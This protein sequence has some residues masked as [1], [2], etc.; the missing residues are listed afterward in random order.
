MSAYGGVEGTTPRLD[1]LAR[2]GLRYER[3]YSAGAWTL[4][5]HMTLFTGLLPEQ[6]G[7]HWERVVAPDALA[8]PAA[9]D[10]GT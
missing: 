8:A 5:A 10:P 7:V 9:I 6:H 4:P 2:E 1:A 3:A